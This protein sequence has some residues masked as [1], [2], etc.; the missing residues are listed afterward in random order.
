MMAA[1][2]PTTRERSRSKSA[3]FA[4]WAAALLATGPISLAI[5]VRALAVAAGKSASGEALPSRG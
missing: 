5:A 2:G 1:R 4:V 3:F